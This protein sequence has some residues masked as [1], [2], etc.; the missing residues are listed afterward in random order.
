MSGWHWS[1]ES[2]QTSTGL[3]IS[4]LRVR[5]GSP[6]AKREECS[7]HLTTTGAV[8]TPDYLID[9]SG[10]RYQPRAVPF[11]AGDG[12]GVRRAHLAGKGAL[13]EAQHGGRK[14]GARTQRRSRCRPRENGDETVIP[15]QLCLTWFWVRPSGCNP[16]N[17][18]PASV[19]S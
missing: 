19:G 17:C 15:S 4:D 6:S 11:S 1:R 7:Q 5:R 9:L 10:C 13:S 2:S 14:R 12:A 3:P 18:S 16:K 8:S